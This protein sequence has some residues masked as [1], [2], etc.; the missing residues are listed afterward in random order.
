MH[1]SSSIT[2]PRC[3]VTLIAP[4][5]SLVTT[6]YRRLVM[7]DPLSTVCLKKTSNQRSDGKRHSSKA[8]SP[9]L[10]LG[11]RSVLLGIVFV[12]LGIIVPPN[13]IVGT[14]ALVSNGES[15]KNILVG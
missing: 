7:N 10:L 5:L 14:V 6:V 4:F 13:P 12:L 2:N 1:R 8:L 11:R 15:M 9:A 3:V